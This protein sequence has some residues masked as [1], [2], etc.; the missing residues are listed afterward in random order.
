MK[1]ESLGY[2]LEVRSGDRYEVLKRTSIS[3]YKP[4]A[5]NKVKSCEGKHDYI[6][7]CGI[8]LEPIDD[9]LLEFELIQIDGTIRKE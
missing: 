2:Y 7:K 8:D 1:L 6:T 9:S 4:L 3:D 5:G